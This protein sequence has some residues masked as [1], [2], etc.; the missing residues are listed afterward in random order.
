MT[1]SP[2]VSFA[3]PLPL[4]RQPDEELRRI[5]DEM[6]EMLPVFERKILERGTPNVLLQFNASRKVLR[7]SIDEVGSPDKW[8][9]IG[10]IHGDFFALHTLLREAEGRHPDC[11]VVFLGDLVDRG[12]MP[13]E[14][15]FLLLDWGLRRPGRLAWI[16]GNHD[17]AFSIGHQGVFRSQVHPAELL[18]DLNKRDFLNG[19][20]Q[21]LG[22][23]FIRV[24]SGLPRALL[25]P[26]GLLATHGG[27]PLVDLHPQGAAAETEDAFIEWLN[28]PACLKDF[29]WTR[30]HRK[31]KAI[32][33]RYSSG[34]QY[35]FRDFEA[36]CA[37]KP[38]WFPISR[39]V[40]GHEH[41]RDGFDLHPT[42]VVNP[43]LT[44]RGLGFDEMRQ[45]PGGLATNYTDTLYLA[46][47]VRDALPAL[48]KVAVSYEQLGM[49]HGIVAETP[50]VG[51]PTKPSSPSTG[52]NTKPVASAV[53]EIAASTP[54]GRVVNET[55]HI[56]AISRE[57]DR[58][59]VVR[60]SHSTGIPAPLGKPQ[61][62]K[63]SY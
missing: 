50:L 56:S 9:F 55:K 22:Q 61:G 18:G 59:L 35:G 26:D 13:F 51:S 28:S 48:I 29:T 45:G 43:A 39:M 5:R 15:L 17:I 7:L 44:I 62:S 57:D 20:R 30:I 60:G 42:Y 46:Q 19:F 32:P 58:N 11:R 33:D 1:E 53:P 54:L 14:C 36:F 27:F 47:G 37:L 16:A 34:S 25:F 21:R 2:A 63:S 10:D 52:S 6:P 24:A 38:H 49:L 3:S 23:F 31:P 4:L 12:D 40:T 8:F 41:P